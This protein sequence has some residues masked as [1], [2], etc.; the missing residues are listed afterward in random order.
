VELEA[1]LLLLK[2]RAE[3]YT[4]SASRIQA[5]SSIRKRAERA[6]FKL[7]ISRAAHEHV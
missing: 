6:G 4:S 7:L 5:L 2:L 1:E 3:D